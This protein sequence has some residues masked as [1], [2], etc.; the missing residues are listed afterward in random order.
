MTARPVKPLPNYR[1]LRRI[2]RLVVALLIGLLIAFSAWKATSEYNLTVRGAEMQSRGYA[3][4]LKE[5]ADRTF[6]EADAVLSDLIAHVTTH[7]DL[8][9]QT[10]ENLLALFQ[11]LKQSTPQLASL[12]LLNRDGL[13][14]AHSLPSPNKQ[15]SAA[16]RDFFIHHRDNPADDT[17]FISK[18]FKNRLNGDWRIT[19]SRPLRTANGEFNGV[20]AVGLNLTYFNTFYSSLDLGK[21]GKIAMVRKDGVLL[22]AQP[23]KESDYQTDFKKSH[24]IRTYLPK[25]AKGTF[26]IAGG[27]ALLEPGGRIISYDSL[28]RYPVVANANMGLDEVTANWRQGTMIQAL[29]TVLV[30]ISLWILSVILL[31]QIRRIEEGHAV[32]LEQQL[33]IETSDKAWESTFDAVADGI[34]VMDLNRNILRANQAT[35]S[36]FGADKDAIVGHL[37]CEVAHNSSTPLATCPFHK[38]LNSG[39]RASMQSHIGGRWY[40]V[41]VDP[42]RNEAGKIT[43]AVHIVSDIT[44]IKQAEESA[45]ESETRIRAL[46]S[47]IPDAIFFKNG[48]GRWLEVNH[49]GI[50]LFDLATTEYHGKDDRELAEELPFYRESL[51]RCVE[52]DAATWSAGVLSRF[53]ERIPAKNGEIRTFESIKIPLF[54]ED[55]SQRGLVVVERDVTDQQQMEQ[56]LQQAQKM[57]AIGH[58]AGGIAHDFNNLLTPILGYSEMI[59]AR[60]TPADPLNSKVAGITAAAHKAKDLTQQ[61]LSFGRRKSTATSVIDLNEVI[62]GFNIILRRTIRESIT[63]SLNLDPNGACATADRSQIEQVILNMTVNAQDAMNGKG[64]ISIET[65]QIHMEGENVR[66]HPGMSEGDFI[67]L[68]FH[69]SGCGMSPEVMAHIFEPF[70]TTKA[71][72]HGTGLGLATVYGIVKQHNGHISVTSRVGLGTTFNIYFPATRVVPIERPGTTPANAVHEADSSTVL[73]VEDNEMVRDMVREMLEGYGYTPLVAAE[74]EEAIAIAKAHSGHI[75][76]MVSDI[77]MPGLSGPEVYEQLLTLLPDLKVVYISG[78]PMNPSLRKG[79]LEEEVSCYLQ[80]PFTAEALIERIRQVLE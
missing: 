5:H 33:E 71:V 34:W 56:Q 4:A 68:A 16:D 6:T 36:I 30:S 46:L 24:L 31:R 28:S 26:R 73:V 51:L 55:G 29:L 42:I 48:E 37:C 67:L 44:Y 17:T 13:L 78:Y 59:A 9:T 7:G 50:E 15:A 61:L 32:Q 63:I 43:G 69:D 64:E 65:C 18:P 49:A 38:M 76:L 20:A 47:A 1:S 39:A 70:Y 14:F 77:V 25:A 35:S 57:E 54:K 2:V 19:L 45:L 10:S 11:P 60:L 75:P 40:E 58:L 53:E 8:S 79:T 27:K 41:S 72:G 3:A 23:F 62:E 12:V 80:K 52:T 74:G 66:L 22:L 21:K